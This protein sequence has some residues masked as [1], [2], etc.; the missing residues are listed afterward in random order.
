MHDVL[1]VVLAGGKGSRL[2][3][4]TRDRA[5][6]AVPFGGAYRIIDFALSNCINS[7]IRRTLV[8]TQYKALSLE[9]HINL[10]WRNLLSPELGEFIDILPPQQRIDEHWYQGT[11]DAV[12]QNIYALEKAQPRLLVI[13]AGDH[14]YKMDYARMV[15][16]HQQNNAELT[17]GALRVSATA[18]RQ[19]GVMEVDGENRIRGFQEKPAQPKT[20]PGDPSHALASM[21]IYVFN[22][23]FLF[24]QLCKD[25]TH[26]Q[27]AH[28]FGRDIIPSIIDSYRVFA[29]PF[30]DE[31]RKIDAYWRDV[32]T[33]DAYHEANMDLISVDPL[34]NMYDTQWPIRTYHRNYPPPKFVFAEEGPEGRRGQALDSIVCPGSI[35]S[36][37]SVRR[38]ILGNGTRIN[39][40]ATV[41]DSILFDDVDIGRRARIRRAIIDKGVRIPP[42]TVVG[43]DPDHDRA[44][45]FT[46]SE[47]GVTVIAQLESVEH[48]AEA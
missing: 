48:F 13:L 9:R 43:F 44:R 15:A 33:L 8:L 4:L 47:G 25:A 6:P 37:G 46:V 36:G 18:A 26:Q 31:N 23:R 29:F 14:I 5:K 2:E 17:I 24:E 38:S 28:D 3:P 45:G 16:F 32:G 34:L 19:F 41:E 21:G 11:A 40:F 39:S 30:R 35:L 1:A 20:L 22:A 10:G 27:S 12:Y 7:N 42:G